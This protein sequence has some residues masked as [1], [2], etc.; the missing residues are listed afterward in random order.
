MTGTADPRG[1]T[2]RG[3]LAGMQDVRIAVSGGVDSMTLAHVAHDLLGTGAT[4]VHAVSPAVPPAAT[5]RVRAH[6]GWH[7]WQLAV[8]DAG[9]FDD[10][11]YRANPVNRCFYC[12]SNLYGAIA[13]RFG[14]QILSG[15]NNDDLGDYRPGL[16]AAAGHDVRHPYVEAGIDKA[17]VR[18]LATRYGLTDLAEL[19]ASPCLSSRILTGLAVTEPRL[20]IVLAVE[21]Q[22]QQ[23]FGGDRTLRCRVNEGGVELQL[24][25]AALARWQAGAGVG[26]LDGIAELCR[27]HGHGQQVT[28]ARYRQGS[29][30]VG[31]KATADD[32]HAV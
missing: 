21:E 29:A 3:L 28:V 22:L 11:D 30:F 24:D 25:E 4:M 2:L 31:D 6:A 16:Q 13:R 19:P 27:R 14:G 17:G 18:A 32:R 10:P 9:E 5:A 23:R 8:I 7:G 15:T 20:A 1:Q 12:K 26:L